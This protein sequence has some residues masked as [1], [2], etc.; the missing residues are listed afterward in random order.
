MKITLTPFHFEELLKKGFSL[1]TI[2]MLKMIQ[3]QVDIKPF[4]EG[5]PKIAAL[6][7]SLIR[8][9]LISDTDDKIIS[10]GQE[11]L[12]FIDSKIS[13]KIVRN[14]TDPT[15]FD[16]WWNSYPGTDTFIHKGVTFQGA[17]S[18]RV[19]RDECRTKFDKIILEGEYTPEV[20]VEALLYDVLQKK[21]ISFKKRENKLSYMQNSLTYLNQKSFEPFI[22]L[23]KSGAKIVETFAPSGGVDI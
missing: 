2:F 9:A 12:I 3:D 5:S 10:L 11:L 8:K 22:E 1:D 19:N 20:M 7:Q 21:E 17:R 16:S 18:L 14:K 15:T 4:I 13:K 6:Y 23:I